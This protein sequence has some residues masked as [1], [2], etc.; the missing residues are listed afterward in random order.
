[1]NRI[2]RFLLRMGVLAAMA[3]PA[4]AAPEEAAPP[5]WVCHFDGDTEGWI[6][7]DQVSGVAIATREEYVRAGGGALEFTYILPRLE[8]FQQGKVPPALMVPLNADLKAARSL[9]FWLRTDQPTA[10]FVLLSE[11]DGSQYNT[12][13]YSPAETW[14]QIALSLDRFVLGDD[15]TD[16]NGRLDPDQI[17]S[18][19][20]MDASF[21]LA[22]LS[23]Q[24][25]TVQEDRQLWMDEFE[26]LSEEVSSAYGL[27]RENPLPLVL[28][29]FESGFLPWL[30]VRGELSLDEDHPTA[31]EL[32]GRPPNQHA[33]RWTHEGPAGQIVG[34][35][36]TFHLPPLKGFT[37]LRLWVKSS[38]ATTLV[39]FFEE[40]ADRTGDRS[41]YHHP[42]PVRADEW[43]EVILPLSEFTRDEGNQDDNDQLDLN[44]VKAM[45]LAD[46]GAIAGQTPGASIWI[47]GIVLE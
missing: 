26:I 3:I 41:S 47:D 14:Q 17:R 36:R 15:S 29:D 35:I 32:P 5:L 37:Q 42:F 30:P 38:V 11:A 20:L 28:D 16:E 43:Q 10:M 4:E 40:V 18:L 23:P 8:Q 31:P 39:A 22:A 21:F 27:D 7:L 25:A 13:F 19:G 46:A 12:A 1:M 44:E 6:S 45:L 9:R 34:L 33:M 2:N 24:Q